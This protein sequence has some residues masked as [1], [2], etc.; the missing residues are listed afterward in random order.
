[1]FKIRHHTIVLAFLAL[2]VVMCGVFF[3]IKIQEVHA[4]SY[5]DSFTGGAPSNTT[6]CNTYTSWRNSLYSGLTYNEIKFFGT[7]Q[8]TGITCTGT[9]ANTL[10]QGL[11]ADTGN[12]TA[13]L[14]NGWYWGLGSCGGETYTELFAYQGTGG[15]CS[16]GNDYDI[17]PCI[18][19]PNWGGL[20]ANDSCADVSQTIQVVCVACGDN[21]TEGSEVCDDGDL[22]TE[23]QCDYGTPA[24]TLCNATC[25]AT[26][27]LT[28]SYCSDSVVDGGYGEACDDGNTAGGDGC[29]AACT[30]IESGYE[31]PT[32][33]SL[34][35][36]ICGDGIVAGTEACD[37][38]NTIWGDGCSAGCTA[39]EA[40]YTCPT[41]GSACIATCGDGLIKGS[42]T[43]DDSGT[44]AGDGCSASCQVETSYVC[45]GVPSTCSNISCQIGNCSSLNSYW[46][47]DMGTELATTESEGGGL[48]AL[49]HLDEASG[50]LYDETTNN[51]DGSITGGPTYNQA[52]VI[53]TSLYFDGDDGVAIGTTNR[54]TNTFSFGGWIRTEVTHEIDTE[55][56]TSAAGTSGQIYAFGAENQATNGGAGLSVGTNGITVYEHG[57]GYM[58]PIA[59]Y[60]GNVGTGWNHIMVVYD[61]HTPMIY[62]NG[63]LV[64]VGLTSTKTLV[65]APVHLGYGSYG[66][67][68]GYMDEIA[69]WNRALSTEEILEL[70]QRGM[71]G[72]SLGLSS[73]QLKNYNVID[74]FTSSESW[75][76]VQMTGSV[77]GGNYVGTI[78]NISD[79]Y[80]A[81]N[82]TDFEESYDHLEIYYQSYSSGPSAIRLY[83]IDGTDCASY[84][85]T[86]SQ[87]WPIISDGNW[88][89][90]DVPITD[91]EWIDDD[92]V[93][94]QIRF[95][96]DG[97]ASTGT[98]YLDYIKFYAQPE[99]TTSGQIGNALT[100]D[101]LN[102][103]LDTGSGI[104]LASSDFTIGSWVRRNSSG[105]YH[106][107]INQG[108]A[109]TNNG[110]HFGFRNT[111]VFMCAFYSN[112]L[113]TSATYTDTDWHHWA[114]TYDAGTNARTLYRDGVDVAN[115]VAT[116]D[117][118]GTGNFYIGNAFNASYFD[119]DLDEVQVWDREL[120]P[121]E[122]LNIYDYGIECG[123]SV[124]AGNE[125][126]D[127][128]G[129]SGGDGCS[130]TCE[131]ETGY[132]C[133][134]APS[135]CSQDIT[136]ETSNCS[137]LRGWWKLNESSGTITDSSGQQ[138]TGA[139]NGLTY[140][141]AGQ[142][143]TA[144]SF[145][146]SSDYI[147]V[148][149]LGSF[150]SSV[151]TSAI[152]LWFKSTDT[153]A[154]TSP[155][156]IIDDSGQSVD[157]VFGIDTNRGT[158][159]TCYGSTVAG[160]TLFTIRSNANE[161]LTRF[162]TDNIYDGNFHHIVMN[163]VDGSANNMDIYVD[164]QLSSTTTVGC[165]QSPQPGN[166]NDWTDNLVIGANNSRGT[167]IEYFTGTLDDVQIWD[168]SLTS[169]EVTDLYYG[170]CGNGSVQSA[171]NEMCDDSDTTGGD[172]C[173]ATCQIETGYECTGSPSSCSEI[174]CRVANC[175]GLTG[176]WK[177]NESSGTIEDSS[178]QGNDGTYNGALYSRASGIGTAVG[179]NGST[180]SIT[181]GDADILNSNGTEALTVSAWVKMTDTATY[182]SIISKQL[183]SGN[184]NGWN[185]HKD[186]DEDGLGLSLMSDPS[187][188]IQVNGP[189]LISDN[190]WHH[191][192]VTYDGSTN[193]SGVNLYVD[194]QLET[195]LTTS[196]DTY[197]T[198]SSDTTAPFYIGIS[199]T[200]AYP[201]SGDV[202]EV[203]VWNRVLTSDERAGLYNVGVAPVDADTTIF[204]TSSGSTNFAL[205]TDL[206][207]VSN[208][209]LADTT[210]RFIQWTNPVDASVGDD[211][212]TYIEMGTGYVSVDVSNLDASLDAT[213]TVSVDVTSCGT[214]T[215]YHATQ[216]VTSL[217]NLKAVGSIVGTG[218]NLGG[219]SSGS[220]TSWC[221]NPTC[222]A[223][224][225]K[226]SFTAEGFDG[227]GGEGTFTCGDAFMEGVEE[228]DDGNLDPG[229]GC[230]GSCLI[231]TGWGCSGNPSV[232]Q[233]TTGLTASGSITN[234]SP[235]IASPSSDGG[236]SNT[237]PTDAWTNVNFS[238]W[239]ND[240]NSDQY[241]LA[242]C[243]TAAVTPGALGTTPNPPTCASVPN[244]WAISSATNSNFQATV[245]Y[246]TSGS[247]V[248]LNN[249]YAFVCDNL[250]SASG[251]KCFPEISEGDAKDGDPGYPLAYV[252]FTGV[253]NDADKV[254]VEGVGYEFDDDAVF[255][256]NGGAVSVDIST[257]V[258][259]SD[260]AS[261]LQAA[262]A[263]NLS[264]AWA[265]NRGSRVYVYSNTASGSFG[266]GV[267]TNTCSCMFAAT[268]SGNNDNDSPFIVN[269][270]PSVISS[271]K[272]VEQ[273]STAD[274]TPE[275]G[276]RL[277]FQ[278]DLFDSSGDDVT[279][280]VC[281]TTFNDSTRTCDSEELCRSTVS[282]RWQAQD[283]GVTASIDVQAVE[284]V[285][286]KTGWWVGETGNIRKTTDGGVTW[287]SQL[288]GGQDVYDISCPSLIHCM[289]ARAGT[290]SNIYRTINGGA[291]WTSTNPN[292]GGYYFSGVHCVDTSTCYA[293]GSN[294]S[295][296][297][298]RKTSDFG[299]TNWVSQT[300]PA[301]TSLGAVHCVDANTCWAT[302]AFGAIFYTADGGATSWV[303]QISGTTSYLTN[304]YA[305][306]ANNVYAV[307]QNGTIV[308]T[309]NGGTDWSVVT[310]GV[311]GYLSD[312]EC[313]DANRC[314]VASSGSGGIMVYTT[315]GF[316]TWDT[317]SLYSGVVS[318]NSISVLDENT[319]WMGAYN[320]GM[321]KRENI[322]EPQT[323]G[324]GPSVVWRNTHFYDEDTGWIVGNN[325]LIINTT[326]SGLTW[327]QQTSGETARLDRI[328]M[329]DANNGWVVGFSDGSNGVILNTTNGGTNWTQQTTGVPNLNMYGVF[330]YDATTAWVVGATGTIL[331]TI[332]SGSNWSTQ[333]SGT[334][335]NILDVYCVDANNCWA[336]GNTG[337]ILNTINGGATAWSVQS[338]P[339]GSQH[340]R[341]VYFIDANN[342]WAVT[343]SGNIIN[344]VNGGTTWTAQAQL[345]TDSLNDIHFID[346]N[347]GWVVGINDYF[348]TTN[349]GGTTWSLLDVNLDGGIWSIYFVDADHGWIVGSQN[350]IQATHVGGVKSTVC[351]E[352]DSSPALLYINTPQAHD[353]D[354]T[355]DN[356]PTENRY[357]IHAFDEH[358][359]VDDSTNDDHFIA[360]E[361]VGPALVSYTAN[362]TP[363]LTAGG[364]DTVDFSVVVSD[365]NGDND[366]IAIEGVLF[367]KDSVSNS[368][369][370][371]DENNCYIDGTCT[372]DA[373]S[374]ADVNRQGDC[375]ITMYYNA[376]P[377]SNWE[378]QGKPT[379]GNGKETGLAD[380]DVNITVSPLAAVDLE[381]AT[382]AYGSLIVDGES[383]EQTVNIGNA[384]NVVVDTTVSGDDMCVSSY[385]PTCPA[386]YIPRARQEWKGSSF[387]WGTG[388]TLLSESV[389]GSGDVD[390]KGCAD[391]D[392][393]VRTDR[394]TPTPANTPL[395][396]RLKIPS[397]QVT[398]S[399]YGQNTLAI[400][401][402][403]QC[404]GTP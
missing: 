127:D 383:A 88:H 100:F 260:A 245:N 318:T 266:F 16:C 366:V 392:L 122:I 98:V 311:L 11:K 234:T 118:L 168:R 200:G 374:G 76:E 353:V 349:D 211:Y 244:T 31:C 263:A 37:D 95:D 129:T 182:Q 194:G 91:A 265:V 177:L 167:V 191:V 390:A 240:V 258:Y 6:Q 269:H 22:V 81:K 197:T 156:K 342:G 333:I 273:Y 158:A 73:G 210:N 117:F 47:M 345:A 30:A 144:I 8:P 323:S 89:I 305:A 399:Y 212:D 322:W 143:D 298:L 303:A 26:L 132:S 293:V 139:N 154:I 183:Q 301:S 20:T 87:S 147:D 277:Q 250:P 196:Y 67:L 208:L 64:R 163:V 400:I 111:D 107:I 335:N 385:Q 82:V 223:A 313:L 103:V 93:I 181:M 5:S 65:Y 151:E 382:I 25:T 178:G 187:N 340:H 57:S 271:V 355:W 126:C 329:V 49:L 337:T 189:T 166:F 19:N 159:A 3:G 222:D 246:A 396:W 302:G 224:T 281:D 120:T 131:I 312:I 334:T 97:S 213:A 247:D 233:T 66:N 237:T 291:N 264:T 170:A 285:D 204:E 295:N 15:G 133:S 262:L 369:S 34:C 361:D 215:I 284:M 350:T 404:T 7:V 71:P 259:A 105:A 79:P 401:A 50:T 188:I 343:N 287:V 153:S 180:D 315:D 354:G 171:T 327:T 372:L 389:V 292:A 195:G 1:M 149:R 52:G 356:S 294:G 101:G 283:S 134:G 321:L 257:A 104:N 261:A 115:D 317:Q 279:G 80:M 391:L 161:S 341:A 376:K 108:S 9:F 252:T 397:A 45:S 53:G 148:G 137:G 360:V 219:T 274:D 394:G 128:G 225:K 58:P 229:D 35:N 119:G 4:A 320:G 370:A 220:C 21:L 388:H 23:T 99:I 325:G 125:G 109:S 112:D 176:W 172:G 249:W 46:K 380:S 83:Y 286:E 282:T 54:P 307:G 135:S 268:D 160:N 299:A 174:G 164:G 192:L 373:A 90:L 276:Q 68:Q 12:I 24:C 386:A 130:A 309:T 124:V 324:F 145:N 402:S 94:Q 43:C 106:N 242:I 184:Y 330:A 173:N 55:S 346:A 48:V 272:S 280:V 29:N 387:S 319:I 365:G 123:D 310:T 190:Q 347:N 375:Q 141:Q 331:K 56:N 209:K 36:T 316:A 152:S 162:I 199:D 201:L 314:Y 297:V 256:E 169:G 248:S 179:F 226:L 10:C 336:V 116:E 358:N 306:D 332:D 371:S 338:T 193:V 86:C 377:G 378:V 85:S 296:R 203:M 216:T 235:A 238:A 63:E 41:P 155:V 214:W 227:G 308:K 328:S 221:S 140:N 384:G 198:G 84:S 110:L 61:D 251:P 228:C 393:A 275:P 69:V 51:N 253:P 230:D 77:S 102:D 344:T 44:G 232:C 357:T 207:S 290:T 289:A 150:G 74:E 218:N 175:N 339:Y 202:D 352:S 255:P 217:A 398:G 157:V 363:V 304:I 236:S 205:E 40:G 146:G 60:Q 364:S 14:C 33:G 42:E 368:C 72:D 92:N 185:V 113:N 243:K 381:E 395:Y 136:C 18:L 121:L 62:L 39:I 78:T 28:G 348:A 300:T 231:E 362:D 38:S 2:S 379:D 403:D 32:P 17:R 278:F 206:S 186:D 27:N 326:N 13:F 239:A 96:F 351:I 114:C 270:A 254:V 59:V 241:F 267:N 359:L 288:T 142:V 367:N 138:R 70:Y 165:S 75:S